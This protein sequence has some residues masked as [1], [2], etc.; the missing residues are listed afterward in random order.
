[1]LLSI[2]LKTNAVVCCIRRFPE[3]IIYIVHNETGVKLGRV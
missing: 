3:G 2:T 1:M